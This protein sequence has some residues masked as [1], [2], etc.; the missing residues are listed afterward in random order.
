MLAKQ[1]LLYG[2]VQWLKG[3][4][5]E[6]TGGQEITDYDAVARRCQSKTGDCKKV[7]RA[8]HKLEGQCVAGRSHHVF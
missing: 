6:V 4:W 8:S 7:R 3:Y 1:W 5:D 2:V